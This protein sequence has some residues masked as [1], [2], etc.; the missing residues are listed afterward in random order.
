MKTRKSKYLLAL[1]VLL[2]TAGVA[3]A[4]ICS[5]P[6][7]GYPT[8]QA[9]ID[10]PTCSTI[11]VAPGVYPENVVIPRT[12]VLNGAQATQPVAGRTSGGPGESTVVGANPAGS[13]AVFTVN[14]PSVTID[15]FTIENSVTTDAAIGVQVSSGSSDAVTLNNFIAGITTTGLGATG[16]AAGIWV[17]DGTTNVNIGKNDIRNVTANGIASGILIGGNAPLLNPSDI[18]YMH[19]NAISGITSAA[20]G[21]AGARA[22]RISFTS[23]S[24]FFEHNQISNLTGSTFADGVRIECPVLDAP[25]INNDFTGLSSVSGDVVAICFPS[26]TNGNS[27][28]SSGNNFNLPDTAF[29]IRIDGTFDTSLGSINA[30]CCWWGSP[31]G[32]G[33]VGPGHGARVSPNINFNLW[34][35][36]PGGACAGSNTPVTETDCKNGGWI[37]HVRP[38]GTIFKSQ[39]DCMQFLN[40]AK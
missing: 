1:T 15:G 30:G 23:T 13:Q 12:V 7:S 33:P 26:N 9:A 20:D 32:P 4:A 29:G 27:T 19:E 25:I 34:R 24:F 35:M 28:D 6:S 14:G 39:G 18:V 38:D 22:V 2:V 5:V 3:S 16:T 31:D 11:N 37:T 17:Q 36:V 40:N 8:I 21:A 10:D